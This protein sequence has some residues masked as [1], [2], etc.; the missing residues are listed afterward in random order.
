MT[1]RVLYVRRP[2]GR[3]S[4]YARV[5]TGAESA[6]PPDPAGAL[7]WSGFVPDAIARES[8]RTRDLAAA[9]AGVETARFGVGPG[10]SEED[11]ERIQRLGQ[12]G[13]SLIGEGRY[14]SKQD[15]WHHANNL[16]RSN[17]ND[18]QLIVSGV[19]RLLSPRSQCFD[20]D[21]DADHRRDVLSL[22]ASRV[23]SSSFA[24]TGAEIA[25]ALHD[26]VPEC[27]RVLSDGDVRWTAV[28]T[29]SG[30]LLAVINGALEFAAP[31]VWRGRCGH[32]GD[33]GHS[34]PWLEG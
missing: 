32:H 31:T 4:G 20:I 15:L 25:G 13:D 21:A 5:P 17:D 24:R 7:G 11:P 22:R 6:S 34:L 29:G 33:T 8:S 2:G 30:V 12:I 9:V 14:P 10:L 23:P 28:L 3:Y 1:S 16:P 19:E 27:R 26:G 18:E